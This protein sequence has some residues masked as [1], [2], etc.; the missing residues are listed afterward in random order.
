MPL[1]TIEGEEVAPVSLPQLQVVI[2]GLVVRSVPSE[3]M[4]Y[5]VE[6]E[7]QKRNCD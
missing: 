2:Q 6:K 1:R 3:L 7:T 4:N 5:L